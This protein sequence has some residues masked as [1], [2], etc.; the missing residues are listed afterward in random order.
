MSS[1]HHYSA[2]VFNAS[3]RAI[4]HVFLRAASNAT[5]RQ[6]AYDA[7][8]GTCEAGGKILVNRNGAVICE[9]QK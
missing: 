9:I 6:A 4:E 7:C 8:F 2:I 3:G 1:K 5:A